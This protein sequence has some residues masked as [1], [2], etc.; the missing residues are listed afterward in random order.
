MKKIT[1]IL[2]AIAGLLLVI[3][4][5]RTDCAAFGYYMKDGSY[6][7]CHTTATVLTA[8]G[9][10]ITV[11]SIIMFF[12]G[13]EKINIIGSILIALISGFGLLNLY[14]RI[15]IP[16]S[17]NSAKTLPGGCEHCM[18]GG[19]HGHMG[20]DMSGMMMAHNRYMTIQTIILAICLVIAI[21]AIFI[22]I[23]GKKNNE[24]KTINE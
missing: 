13:S 12:V 20:V 6:M 23:L 14:G 8:L 22:N 5:L 24:A 21:V 15:K 4:P 1:T 3:L 16:L 9:I 2:L 10:F 17:F 19:G 18:M 7:G 11:L